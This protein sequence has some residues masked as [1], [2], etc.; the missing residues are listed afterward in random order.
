MVFR[1]HVNINIFTFNVISPTQNVS[2]LP[3]WIMWVLTECSVISG[4]NNYSSQKTY[5]SLNWKKFHHT[6]KTSL[7]TKYLVWHLVTLHIHPFLSSVS[8]FCRAEGT[9]TSMTNT[10]TTHRIQTCAYVMHMNTHKHT[11][12]S[13]WPWGSVHR[14]AE[15]RWPVCRGWPP[16]SRRPPQA[17][18]TSCPGRAPGL[19][20]AG[21]RRTCP[22]CS[23]E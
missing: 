19:R 22:A 9:E 23:P 11:V 7:K 20:R 12:S 13:C 1:R 4:V 16:G 5:L 18:R 2:A 3:E 8:A 21:T 6:T 14:R 10:T 17:H 15:S